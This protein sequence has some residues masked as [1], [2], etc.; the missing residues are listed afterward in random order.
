[1]SCN[2]Y[3]TTHKHYNQGTPQFLT[4]LQNLLRCSLCLQVT[5]DKIWSRYLHIQKRSESFPHQNQR[6]TF[7]PSI[8]NDQNSMKIWFSKF[9]Y[10][11]PEYYFETMYMTFLHLLFFLYFNCFFFIEFWSIT[12]EGLKGHL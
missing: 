1:M 6:C 4:Y 8:M 3:I 5:P 7:S 10:I 9:A 2:L 11:F 12:F